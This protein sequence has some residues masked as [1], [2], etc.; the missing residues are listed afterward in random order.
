M[1]YKLLGKSGLKVAELSLGTMTFGT[2]SG[3]GADKAECD[4]QF[5]LYRDLGGNFVDT[6]NLYTN[7]T[8]ETFLGEFMQGHRHELV[9]ATKY[10]LKG[11][12][13]GPNAAGNS[14][15]S[16]MEAIEGS[17]KRLRTDY[18]DLFYLHAWDFLTPVDEIMR[19]LDDLVKQGKVNYLGISDTPAWIVS[20]ANTM[21]ELMGW[22]RFVALQ[23]EYSLIQ[24]TTERDLV[25]MA[26]ELGLGIT[27]WAPLA[28]G[29]LSGKY[30]KPET[31]EGRVKPESVRRN[32][33]AQAIAKAV[34]ELAETKN[35]HPVQ[36]ALRWL[37][38][39]PELTFPIVGA[40]TTQ[41]LELSLQAAQ[42]I[43]TAEE[44][45][46]LNAI[47]AIELGF[48]H[49]FLTQQGVKDVLFNGFFDKIVK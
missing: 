4:R 35:C 11:G 8:S 44:V 31:A 36:V 3:Y 34:V 24:R 18:I 29:A 47:S 46:K 45:E 12:G 20:R 37:M 25:P 48:P 33:R 1:I 9:L 10:S 49:E 6:A 39:K 2:E 7:G 23:A 16:M 40:R 28:G 30:L 42:I 22:T 14:R 26:H 38:Q 15:K 41:Q 17:L 19:G 27:A 5:S 13:K 21:A 43:L 32:D